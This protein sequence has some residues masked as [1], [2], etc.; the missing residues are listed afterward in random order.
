MHGL[1]H[2]RLTPLDVLQLVDLICD[3]FFSSSALIT[4][5]LYFQIITKKPVSLKKEPTDLNNLPLRY[6]QMSELL[7]I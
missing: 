2:E 5:P 1:V 7:P 4:P 6:E 3:L